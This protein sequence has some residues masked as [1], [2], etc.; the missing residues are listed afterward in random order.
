MK[1][2]VDIYLVRT[3]S[4]GTQERLPAGASM[5][6]CHGLDGCERICHSHLRLLACDDNLLVSGHA[7]P[8]AEVARL[9][10]VRV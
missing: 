5:A 2:P 6:D 4:V 9:E 1:G 8:D 7:H 3:A 10:Q